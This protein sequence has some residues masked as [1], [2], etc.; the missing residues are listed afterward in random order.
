LYFN[1]NAKV[2][3]IIKKNKVG[4]GRWHRGI[5]SIGGIDSI[6]GI[7]NIGQRG[8]IL[9]HLETFYVSIFDILIY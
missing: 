9:D 7:D 8:M 2:S 6:D 5:D 3:K 1:H 4:Q